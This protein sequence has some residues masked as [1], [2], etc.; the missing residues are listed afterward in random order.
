MAAFHR[1]L[2]DGQDAP[3]ALRSAQSEL[4]AHSPESFA[5]SMT[6]LATIEQQFADAHGLPRTDLTDPGLPNEVSHPYYWGAFT[7]V[8]RQ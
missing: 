5:C 8:A 1:A 7:C 4:R 3:T 6:E 2:R